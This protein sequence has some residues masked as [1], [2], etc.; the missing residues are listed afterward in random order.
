MLMTMSEKIKYY[1]ESLD[2]SQE[3]LGK[4]LN[5]PVVKE[6]VVEEAKVE[7]PVKEEVVAEEPVVE[8]TTVEEPEVVTEPEEVVE[9]PSITIGQK[10]AL[11]AAESYL[12]YT[13]F[14][15]TGLIEQ[16]KF[17][18]YSVEDATYAADNC[19]ADWN[20]QAAIHAKSY[21]DYTSFSRGSLIEQLKFDGFTTEQAEYGATAVGY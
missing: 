17:E 10:N 13:S 6:E 9:E 8:P 12:A 21:L 18:E 19:G 4:H 11:S 20:E 7:E 2:W 16:L 14:S 3:E 15:Y 5:P 1:R